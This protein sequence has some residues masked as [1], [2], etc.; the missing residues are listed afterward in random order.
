MLARL[1]VIRDQHLGPAE[2]GISRAPRAWT[3][4]PQSQPGGA[5]SRQERNRRQPEEGAQGEQGA[6]PIR[7]P[8]RIPQGL[9][10]S[11]PIRDSFQ[12]TRFRWATG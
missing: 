11:G 7:R 3:K 2:Q 4:A 12:G 10:Q 9:K 8:L 5:R 6:G 1:S